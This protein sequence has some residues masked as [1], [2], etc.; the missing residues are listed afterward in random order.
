MPRAAWRRTGADLPWGDPL[1][2]HRSLMEGYLWRFTDPV[3]HRVLEVA[4]GVSHQHGRAWGTVVVAASPLSLVRSTTLD[5]AWAG[6][7]RFAIEAAPAL[8][9]VRDRT[10][11]S[12]VRDRL[13]VSLDDAELEVALF[14][15]TRRRTLLPGA[16]VFSLLPGLNHYWHPYLFEARAEGA[17]R[18]GDEHWD[19][20]GCQVYAEK[21]WGRGF[22]PAWWWGQAQDFDRP[23]VRVAFAGGLL[24]RGRATVPVNGLVLCLGGRRLDLFP[25]AAIVRG[26]VRADHWRLTATGPRH[27]VRVSGQGADSPLLRLPIPALTPHH[28]GYSEQHLAGTVR[29]EVT[30]D[31]KPLYAG[32]S[33]LA[34][35]ERG[36]AP[37]SP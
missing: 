8:S 31:G 28:L 18:L 23:D 14:P 7:D 5:D 1:P 17:A 20:A 13:R 4:C 24:G 9:F 10:G 32:T 2:S 37:R 30:R 21:S 29:L 27:R 16:G 35:L 26:G 15:G 19:L 3:R 12:G 6:T 36:R 25:P 22:P 34:S 11:A 33:R